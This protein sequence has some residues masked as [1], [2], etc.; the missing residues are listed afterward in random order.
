LYLEPVIRA[1]DTP[2]VAIERGAEITQLA[3]AFRH[4]RVMARPVVVG[5]TRE[6]LSGEA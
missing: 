2:F 5:F 4:S 6:V 1:I 3:T